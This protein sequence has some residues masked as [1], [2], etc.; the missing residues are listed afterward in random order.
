MSNVFRIRGKE[1]THL[2]K[3]CKKNNW[4]VHY[5]GKMAY[6][7]NGKGNAEAQEVYIY[8]Y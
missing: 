3:W 1:N 7:T 6:A 8:N 5:F 2:I 4:K